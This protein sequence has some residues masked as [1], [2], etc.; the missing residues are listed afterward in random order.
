M[1]GSWYV[2]GRSFRRDS[3]D[4]PGEGFSREKRN[5]VSIGERAYGPRKLEKEISRAYYGNKKKRLGR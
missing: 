2:V 5:R 1:T 4:K 3:D